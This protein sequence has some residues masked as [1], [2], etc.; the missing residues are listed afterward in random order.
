[1]KK[2]VA[3]R[4]ITCACG[5]SVPLIALILSKCATCGLVYNERGERVQVGR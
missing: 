2:P 1:M 3:D 4:R 5:Q